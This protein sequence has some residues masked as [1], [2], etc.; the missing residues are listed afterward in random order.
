MLTGIAHWCDT[1]FLGQHSKFNLQQSSGKR[2]PFQ[3]AARS[4]AIEDQLRKEVSYWAQLK[5]CCN[6]S[7][8][9]SIIKVAARNV[10]GM[11]YVRIRSAALMFRLNRRRFAEIVVD[12]LPWRNMSS[13]LQDGT[14]QWKFIQLDESGNPSKLSN[15]LATLT[16]IIVAIA[17]IWRESW[18]FI[19]NLVS[20]I[21]S[22]N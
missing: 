8:G 11:R 2:A 6:K 17:L 5:S 22:I 15:N 20:I 10:C 21:F 12:C 3:F 18:I 19:I 16:I 9:S 14:I 7:R 4:F 13:Q 1:P